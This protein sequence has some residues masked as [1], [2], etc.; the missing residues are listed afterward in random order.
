MLT[1][2]HSTLENKLPYDVYMNG[3]IYPIFLG[4]ICYFI[5]CFIH[6]VTG[7]LNH[8]VICLR[9]LATSDKL[10]DTVKS[11]HRYL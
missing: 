3:E 5:C 8:Q 7:V 9:R 2:H 6:K 4:M 11:E 1:S 10:L